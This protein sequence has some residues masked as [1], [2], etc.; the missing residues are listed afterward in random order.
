[1]NYIDIVILIVAVFFIIRGIKN[2]LI[3]ELAS[4]ISI[5]AGAYI[6]MYFSW[7][8][9]KIMRSS[10]DIQFEYTHAVAFII[11]FIIVLILVKF[12]AKF[13][14]KTVDFTPL[15]VVNK[16]SGAL[17]G[18][19]KALF[20]LSILFYVLNVFDKSESIITSANKDKSLF[21][22]PVSIIAPYT[23]PK[24][25]E[26]YKKLNISDSISSDS[27]THIKNAK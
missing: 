25:R 27:T 18:L 2:G 9:E 8:L 24:I 14:S 12:V 3:I 7:N 10:L 22:K 4:L 5:F 13:I 20:L 23:I 17:F 19:F 15:V 16:T 1:M 26:Q 6:A 11:I 21:Y